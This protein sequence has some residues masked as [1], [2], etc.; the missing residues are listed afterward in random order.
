MGSYESIGGA[1]ITDGF[2]CRDE[3]STFGPTFNGCREG[4][5]TR[6]GLAITRGLLASDSLALPVAE[7]SGPDCAGFTRSGASN[8]SRPFAH[9]PLDWTVTYTDKPTSPTGVLQDRIGRAT[10][11]YAP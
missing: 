5:D 8:A 11:D 2:G 9:E 4:T 6:M 1:T 7:C 10:T 3:G